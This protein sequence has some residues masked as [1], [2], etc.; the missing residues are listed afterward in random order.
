MQG[1]YS[2]KGQ[3]ECA[4]CAGGS[5]Q[6]HSGGTRCF[7][8]PTLATSNPYHTLCT[9]PPSYYGST[10]DEFMQCVTCDDTMV[11]IAAGLVPQTVIAADGF[12]KVSAN[13]TEMLKCLSAGNC[14]SGG[15][16]E[17]RTGVLCSICEDGYSQ[18]SQSS[19]CTKCP[20]PDAARAATAA[21]IIIV[22]LV[23]IGVFVLIWRGKTIEVPKVSPFDATVDSLYAHP[24]NGAGESA[25]QSLRSTISE[26]AAAATGK[27]LDEK[28]PD[29]GGQVGD[30]RAASVVSH[31]YEAGYA[32]GR[33]D[34]A[35]P[36]LLGNA[37][38]PRAALPAHGR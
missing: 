17:H 1:F 11:C 36:N 25:G 28:A 26:A 29:E 35:G 2:N 27:G 38:V 19:P 13:R 7:L 8:C 9:C 31:L 34:R 5:F 21:F 10:A 22:I 15:C 6:P 30:G 24:T 14:L 4:T 37:K 23:V 3:A 16:G 18:S 33:E 12:W 32:F 20:S